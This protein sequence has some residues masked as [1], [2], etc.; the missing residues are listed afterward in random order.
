MI[1]YRVKIK[2][3]KNSLDR[4]S[5]KIETVM[6]TQILKD[7]APYV[8][9][10]GAAAGLSNRAYVDGGAAVYPGPSARFLY[11][12]KVMIDPNT[13]STYAPKGGT[14][15]ATDR[16]LVF[17]QDHHGMATDHWFEASKAE[18]EDKWLRVARKAAGHEFE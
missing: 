11:E 6:A 18:N 8:P 13:G 14:K 3:P 5:R 12:G 4:A 17:R 15:V 1:A 7:T 9:M 16:N 10:S 2:M